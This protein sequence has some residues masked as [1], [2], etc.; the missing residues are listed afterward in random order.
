M[1]GAMGKAALHCA[2][3][4]MVVVSIQLAAPTAH[5]Q[6]VNVVRFDIAPQPLGSAL[7]AFT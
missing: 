2:I 3:S 5:A 4:T 6:T 7:A 1:A